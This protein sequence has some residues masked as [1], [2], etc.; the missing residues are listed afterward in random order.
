VTLIGRQLGPSFQTHPLVSIAATSATP[1]VYSRLYEDACTDVL[2]TAA[3]QF[4]EGIVVADL[5]RGFRC[6]PCAAYGGGGRLT[7]LERRR[8][9]RP[10]PGRALLDPLPSSL[11]TAHYWLATSARNIASVPFSCCWN[12]CEAAYRPPK[13]ILLHCPV[14]ARNSFCRP[15][16]RAHE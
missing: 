1:R 14:I 6:D 2:P 13:R 3:A 7:Y 15:S 11:A 5:A 8:M 9:L 10:L 12:Y 16:S 4:T